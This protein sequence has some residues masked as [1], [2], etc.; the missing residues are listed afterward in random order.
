[1]CEVVTAIAAIASA[2]AS[3]GMGAKNA[4][5]ARKAQREVDKQQQLADP[6]ARAVQE[7]KGADQQSR[8]DT[9]AADEE[10]RR[11]TAVANNNNVL[12]ARSGALGVPNT[13][14][15]ALTGTATRTTMG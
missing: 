7:A 6:R 5:D 14:N 9:E 8:T 3:I 11:R 2:A 4:H 15:T 12:I 10:R 1:M 13:A